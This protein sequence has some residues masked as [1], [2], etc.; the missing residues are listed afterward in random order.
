MILNRVYVFRVLFLFW[1]K[2]FGGLY[3]DMID[4]MKKL[5]M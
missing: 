1:I 2:F 3:I 5:V 4:L